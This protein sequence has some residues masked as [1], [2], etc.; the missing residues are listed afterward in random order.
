VCGADFQAAREANVSRPIPAIPEPSTDVVPLTVAA[1][2]RAA[3]ARAAAARTTR[4]ARTTVPLPA[5]VPADVTALGDPDQV[6]A[7][8]AARHRG[9]RRLGQGLIA[10]LVVTLLALAGFHFYVAEH[11]LPA[12][13]LSRGA[14]HGAGV[15]VVGVSLVLAVAGV[16]GT[17]T[18]WGRRLWGPRS[19]LVYP[20]VV[21]ELRPGWHR[22]ITLE[23]VGAG[24]R[25]I[26]AGAY[27]FPVEGAGALAFDDTVHDAAALAAT[28]KERAAERR[29]RVD[30][31]DE[32]KLA[33]MRCASPGPS[34]LSRALHGRPGNVYRITLLADRLLFQCLGA[35]V[36]SDA[37]PNP[38]PFTMGLAGALIGGFNT[39]AHAAAREKTIAELRR[40]EEADGPTLVR[41]ALE[42]EGSFVAELPEVRELRLEPLSA[43]ANFFSSPRGVEQVCALRIEHVRHGRLTLALLSRDDVMTVVGP[44]AE[45]FGE[46]LTVAIAWSHSR[47]AFIATPRPE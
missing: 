26:L 13:D 8:D 12:Y 41:L 36:L 35:A 5:G 7:T 42:K 3:A 11:P 39:W 14:A 30:F 47:C 22:V 6:Y 16:V 1:P 10:L 17:S 2:T 21:V 37:P 45:V 46:V 31:G 38:A 19:Y 34:V 25:N 23:Q 43:V 9:V 32:A 29:R 24:E 4:T 40:L 20:D 15:G 44:W 28:I 33:E 18:T 27:R